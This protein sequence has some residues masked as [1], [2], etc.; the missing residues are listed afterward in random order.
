MLVP[1][2]WT[3]WVGPLIKVPPGTPGTTGFSSLGLCM[4][5]FWRGLAMIE[6]VDWI[7]L[8]PDNLKCHLQMFGLFCKLVSDLDTLHPICF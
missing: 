7:L 6:V 4:A 1:V 3:K 5:V 8:S 2:L